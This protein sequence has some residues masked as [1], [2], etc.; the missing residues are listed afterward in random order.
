MSTGSSVSRALVTGS[1]SGIGAAIARRL[2][3]D[4][5]EVVGFDRAPA[6]L[7]EDHFRSVSVDLMDASALSTAVAAERGITA[8][9][10]ANTAWNDA[11]YGG[12]NILPPD[13]VI[14]RTARSPK[15][16]TLL[17]EVANAM[18]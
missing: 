2:L 12:S 18:K 10:H 14:R 15:A 5:W 3:N 1:S 13:I 4:G 16:S 6:V 8:L 17:T 9:V 11:Y 7:R